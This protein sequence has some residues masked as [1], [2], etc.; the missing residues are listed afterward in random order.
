MTR[1]A[2]VFLIVNLGCEMMYVI[3]QRLKAQSIT[4]EKSAQG[5]RMNLIQSRKS[6]SGLLTFKYKFAPSK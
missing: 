4:V 3:D 2:N 5:I 1:G 6:G